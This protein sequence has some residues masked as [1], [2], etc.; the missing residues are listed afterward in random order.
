M[1]REIKLIQPKCS[2]CCPGHDM[3]PNDTYK[4]KRSKKQRSLGKAKEH[5]AVRRY[6]KM[7][8]KIK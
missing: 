6:F 3:Y 8:L 5:R 4:N 1:R 2:S 7:S